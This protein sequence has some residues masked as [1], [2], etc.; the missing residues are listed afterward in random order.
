MTRLDDLPQNVL[1]VSI[2][3]YGQLSMFLSYAIQAQVVRVLCSD[4]FRGGSFLAEDARLHE[5][6]PFRHRWRSAHPFAPNSPLP[7]R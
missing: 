4:G 1:A 3:A 2:S 7:R 6:R 5:T